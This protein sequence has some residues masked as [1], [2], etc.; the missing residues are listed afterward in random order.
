MTNT[1]IVL[2]LKSLPD[3]N[4]T[5]RDVG[6]R[7]TSMVTLIVIVGKL[8]ILRRLIILSFIPSGFS[9]GSIKGNR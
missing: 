6:K 4:I 9:K 5:L 2:K 3:K 7:Y 1:V 8:E